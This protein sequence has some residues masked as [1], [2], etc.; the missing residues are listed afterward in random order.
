MR[1]IKNIW[2]CGIALFLVTCTGCATLSRES[3]EQ[4]NWYGI[5]Y[6]DGTDG[7]PQGRL[8]EHKQ[9][10]LEYAVLPDEKSY[11]QGRV[12]G[13]KIYCTDQNGYDEGEDI[14]EYK[15][16]CP[17][18]LEQS[19]LKGYLLGLDAAE[20]KL[21]QEISRRNKDIIKA[22][23]S[24]QKLEGKALKKQK[25]KITRLEREV[26]SAEDHISD[27]YELRR[28]YGLKSKHLKRY[29][30]F[31][32]SNINTARRKITVFIYPKF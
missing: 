3:C 10:C 6:K 7:R 15:D 12:D 16:V 20:N 29:A 27:I 2:L 11:Q 13:L 32:A 19:F 24:L 14:K 26:E 21:H 30:E 25:E 5:G 22:T 17:A 18:E 28:R 4:G 31:Y 23:V 8:L 1:I 9:A